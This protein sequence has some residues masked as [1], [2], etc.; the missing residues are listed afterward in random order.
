MMPDLCQGYVA[1]KVRNNSI[2]ETADGDACLTGSS[3]FKTSWS[4]RQGLPIAC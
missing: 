2:P 4:A 1:E 3:E